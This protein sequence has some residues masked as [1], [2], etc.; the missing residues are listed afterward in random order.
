[1]K[2]ETITV[3]MSQEYGTRPVAAVLVQAA[4]RFNSKIYLRK[5]RHQVNAK[6][7]MGMMMLC[8]RDGDRIQ[9]AAEGADEREALQGMKAC[10]CCR[11]QGRDPAGSDMP[12]G[13]AAAACLAA[14]PVS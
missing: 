3:W 11:K 4:S 7:I 5:D 1:M 6:S 9:L 13:K 2:M 10:L 14:V 8:L 12:D